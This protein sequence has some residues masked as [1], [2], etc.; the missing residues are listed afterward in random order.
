MS[1]RPRRNKAIAEKCISWLNISFVISLA[2]HAALITFMTRHTYL[3]APPVGGAEV[4]M[5][6]PGA[7]AGNPGGGGNIPQTEQQSNQG[8]GGN[9][10]QPDTKNDQGK[11]PVRKST[12]S[13]NESRKRDP[14]AISKSDVTANHGT[15]SATRPKNPFLRAER[16]EKTVSPARERV[17]RDTSQV[18][19]GAKTKASETAQS[20]PGPGNAVTQPGT[21]NAPAN[22]HAAGELSGDDQ[23][24][25]NGDG[26]YTAMSSAGITYKIITDAAPRYPKQ[27]SSLGLNKVVKVRIRFLVGLDGSV[28]SVQILS[29]NIPDLGFKESALS[30]I[31]AMRFQPVWYKGNNIKVFFIKTIVFQP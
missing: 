19:T 20:V 27:A 9:S 6:E 11:A 23:F 25:A 8:K 18:I 13:R 1:I 3:K 14:D 24:V 12:V 16:P 21:I 4:F 5:V 29:E 15:A 22:Q 31:K 7:P 17:V 26:T 2:L 30:A 10:A 28:E